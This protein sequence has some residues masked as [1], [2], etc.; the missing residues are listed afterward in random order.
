MMST[1]GVR[2][3]HMFWSNNVAKDIKKKNLVLNDIKVRLYCHQ[4][5]MEREIIS[6]FVPISQR[7]LSKCEH[8]GFLYGVS[9]HRSGSR[10]FPETGKEFNH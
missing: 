4:I 10:H 8:Q 3:T 5:I 2:S 9:Q 1:V 6:D 7:F